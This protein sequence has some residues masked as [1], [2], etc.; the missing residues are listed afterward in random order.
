MK[1]QEAANLQHD[2]RPPVCM[3][4][5]LSLRAIS[6]GKDHS[7]SESCQELHNSR[8]LLYPHWMLQGHVALNGRGI[9]APLS[10]EGAVVLELSAD[11]LTI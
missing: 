7:P 6:T 9:H 4:V 8:E 1:M 3:F 2:A 11:F 10:A 5:N